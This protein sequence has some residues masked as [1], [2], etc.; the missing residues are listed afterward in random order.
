MQQEADPR[1]ARRRQRHDA[2]LARWRAPLSTRRERLAAWL[3][4]VFVDHGI[5][6]LIYLNLH[7]VGRGAWR[8]GQPAP[9]QVRAFAR[10][11]GRSVVSLRGGQA[12]GSLPLEREACTR[13]GLSF[14]TFVLRSRALPTPEDLRAVKVLLDRLEYPALFH[15]KA[16]ADRAGFMSALYLALVEG[17]PVAEARQQLSPW[18]GHI[19]QGPTG[20]LDAFFDAYQRDTGGQV[21][22]MEWVETDYDPAAITRDFR[23]SGWGRLFTDRLLR[24]E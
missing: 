24:R 19:R 4:M 11:G 21:P 7:R 2:R 9:H 18:Y 12:F 10:R 6:R 14:Q 1:A 3:N 22:L 15:C 20:V 8:S 16:G 5:F 17:A 13:N 23:A